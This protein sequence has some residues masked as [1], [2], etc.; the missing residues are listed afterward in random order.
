ME[1]INVKQVE[2]L[3][4]MNNTDVFVPFLSKTSIDSKPTLFD[5]NSFEFNACTR[6][7]NH[8][9]VILYQKELKLCLGL[10][11]FTFNDRL[12][13]IDIPFLSDNEREN[14]E[15]SPIK[16]VPMIIPMSMET[17]PI[18][19][20]RTK[21]TS[22]EEEDVIATALKKKKKVKKVYKFKSLDSSDDEKGPDL[23]VQTKKAT[24]PE[25]TVIKKD[26]KKEEI[27]DVKPKPT[28]FSPDL[29]K[30]K[31][32][33]KDKNPS[34]LP[35]S[36][37][38]LV[39]SGI[40][41]PERSTLKDTAISLGAQYRPQWTSDSTHLICAMENTDKFWE[42]KNAGG[43]VVTKDWIYACAKKNKKLGEAKFGFGKVESIKDDEDVTDE[44]ERLELNSEDERFIDDGDV[45]G[46]PSDEEFDPDRVEEEDPTTPLFEDPSTPSPVP[47]KKSTPPIPTSPTDKIK[48][49]IEKMKLKKTNIVE[50]IESTFEKAKEYTSKGDPSEIYEH[51][52]ENVPVFSEIR[53]AIA[54]IENKQDLLIALETS[55]KVYL[56]AATVEPDLL[57]FLSP[58]KAYL[59]PSIKDTK[60]ITRLLYAYGGETVPLKE[61]THILCEE[62]AVPNY[63]KGIVV[64]I[65]WILQCHS[66]KKMVDI[67][68]FVF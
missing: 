53:K 55:K 47:V 18:T 7:W 19:K 13:S 4:S 56:K 46:P 2:I 43:K 54:T 50:F 37:V 1:T 9:K 68:P 11:S 42:A 20:K 59:D 31:E 32:I 26:E 40:A 63:T 12:Q 28:T 29:D 49:E 33:K 65:H 64:S 8:A 14:I 15:I 38:I 35:L 44:D 39:I 45:E 58:V 36:K 60:K 52:T 17:V 41:N 62:D 16:T 51:W 30:K 23:F 21:D 6:E 57:D 24:S 61:A 3:V 5:E 67:Q 10:K 25:L 27:I 66:K 48:M 22:T 34:T